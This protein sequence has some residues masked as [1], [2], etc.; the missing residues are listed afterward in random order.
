[1]LKKIF[2]KEQESYNFY[3]C[4]KLLDLCFA[5]GVLRK[6]PNNT[7][8]MLVYCTAG[9]PP[10]KYPKGW[11]SENILSVASEL[12]ADPKG[13]RVI[14]KALRKANVE[15]PEFDKTPFGDDL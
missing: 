3:Q 15:I 5:N 7:D 10:E 12:A 11:Y 9:N 2:K 6:D 13:Q 1:M 14:M 4:I 8:N